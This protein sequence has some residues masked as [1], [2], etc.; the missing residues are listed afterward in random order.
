MLMSVEAETCSTTAD[1]CAVHQYY[2]RGDGVERRLRGPRTYR[3]PSLGDGLS[4]ARPVDV[5]DLVWLMG[6]QSG[7]RKEGR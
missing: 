4:S 3:S 6:E 2:S 1:S 5:A 7:W